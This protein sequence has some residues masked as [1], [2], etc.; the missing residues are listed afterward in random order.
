MKSFR[1][2]ESSWLPVEVFDRLVDEHDKHWQTVEQGVF[3]SDAHVYMT[4][5]NQAML[6]K[7]FLGQA[8]GT[9]GRIGKTARVIQRDFESAEKFA[10]AWLSE[11][12]GDGVDWLVFGL[13]FADFRF[14]LFP[15]GATGMPFCI[16]PILCTCL[17]TDVIALSGL[18]RK[19]FAEVQWNHIDWLIV[20]QRIAC[21][22]KPL[23][24]LG[25]GQD[26]L[27]GVM[28]TQTTEEV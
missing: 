10:E 9:G 21:L 25:D 26:C 23:N 2:P 24:V 12:A 14:H 19:Q 22:E 28:D 18:T 13:S 1:W 3:Q 15:I 8:F 11:A 5:Q 20:E 16:S 27:E 4:A 7:F 6:F 17:R